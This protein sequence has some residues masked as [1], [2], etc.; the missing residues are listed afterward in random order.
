MAL[1]AFIGRV[2]ITAF[3]VVLC[4]DAFDHLVVEK[5]LYILLPIQ[6]RPNDALQLT[7]L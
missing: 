1:D 5:A 3:N 4:F 2:G 6:E 7:V